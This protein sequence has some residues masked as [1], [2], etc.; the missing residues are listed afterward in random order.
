MTRPRSSFGALSWATV[1]K[2]ERQQRYAAP[3]KK[4]ATTATGS[5][6]ASA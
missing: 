2:L 3:T 4:I 1:V 6:G 5:V